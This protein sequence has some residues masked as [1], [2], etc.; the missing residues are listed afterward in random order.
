VAPVHCLA[1]LMAATGV[2][3]DAQAPAPEKVQAPPPL[4]VTRHGEDYT[5]LSDPALRTGAWWEPL[6][7]VRL[8]SDSYLSTGT[9]LRLRYEALEDR[10]WG[11]SPEPDDGYAW[12]RALPYADL[13]LGSSL[14]AFAQLSIT[15]E[16][17][18]AMP[19]SAV[20]ESGIDV[21]Q[22]FVELSAPATLAG[23]DD[24]VSVRAGRQLLSYGAG[25]LLAPRY[26]PNVVQ[27]FDGGFGTIKFGDEWTLNAFYAHPVAQGLGDFD[28]ESSDQSIWAV[29]AV[30]EGVKVFGGR[31]GVDLYYIGYRDGKARFDQGS[32]P[33]ER[34]TVGARLTGRVGNWDWDWEASY[35]FGSFGSG[36]ISA[37]SI[38]TRTGYTWSHLRSAPRLM[39]EAAAISGDA[40]PADP[41]LQTFNALFP[42]GSFFGEL[43]P[44]GPYN[45]IT[46]GPTAS[47]RIAKDVEVEAQALFHW[48]ESVRDGIYNIPGFLVR[49]GAGSRARRIGSQGSLSITWSPARTFDL[50]ATYGLFDAGPFLEETGPAQTTHFLGAEARFRY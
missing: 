12:A 34:H 14:R 24:L 49:S 37:W 23:S 13:R 29:Y 22:A 11:A 25:R 46:A 7:Y 30:R 44:V 41:D 33:E 38:G 28:D 32:A 36:R 3:A 16:A 1:L 45:L 2:G 21:A 20:E 48:R 26:R 27:A 5:Y 9:E 50:T 40:D 8:G 35:Q 47:I 19:K 39:F 15:Y 6:K 42:S 17:G 18:N 43:T 4:S 31:S 10:L